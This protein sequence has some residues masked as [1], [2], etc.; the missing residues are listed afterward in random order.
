MIDEMCIHPGEQN[1]LDLHFAT[2]FQLCWLNDGDHHA[3]RL[4]D[5]RVGPTS[6]AAWVLQPTVNRNRNLSENHS[7]RAVSLLDIV[8]GQL[9]AS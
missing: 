4:R 8:V 3:R 6:D 7:H 1:R 5:P 9:I 2:G